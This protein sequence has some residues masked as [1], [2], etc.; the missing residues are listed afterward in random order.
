VQTPQVSN[1]M[2]RLCYPILVA[3][4]LISGALL[5]LLSAPSLVQA[6]NYQ[7]TN[8]NSSGPGS[9]RQAILDANGNAGHDTITF[10][11]GLTGTIVL[12]SALP[13]VNDHLTIAGPGASVISISGN[14]TSR[15]FE[16]AAGTAVTITNVTIRNGR[17]LEGGGIYTQGT[18]VLSDTNV[19]G[20]SAG[21]NGTGGGV[22]VLRGKVTLIGGQISGNSARLGGGIFIYEG[23]VTLSGGQI[24][25][26][27]AAN[28]G[29]LG[30][31]LESATFTQ[32]GA[33]IIAL[34]S[35][36]LGGG[37]D[38]YKGSVML[39]GGQIASNTARYRGGGVRVSAGT[40]LL[41]GG[42]IISNTADRGGGAYLALSTAI[43]TQ[44]GISSI[45]LNSANSGGGIHVDNG[46]VVISGGQIVSNTAEYY[47]GG[48]FL[49][50]GNVIM[51]GG[52]IVSN[53]AP[54]GGGVYAAG[55][56]TL[57]GASSITLN[58]ANSG[59]GIYV[60][61]G[62]VVING[63]HIASNA[64]KYQGGGVSISG[65]S[66]TLENVQFL[67]NTAGDTGGALFSGAS[68][69][70]TDSCFVGNSAIS[71]YKSGLSSLS[72]RHN[73]WGAANGPSGAGSGDGDSVS[74]NV[75]YG[76]FLTVPIL[77]CPT[78]SPDLAISKR[79]YPSSHIRDQDEV[80]YT[81]GL[82]NSGRSDAANVLL[83]DTLPGELNFARWCAK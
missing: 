7:V 49:H 56:F 38:I 43:F 44:T 10:E 51:S 29:G 24:I 66:T 64:A 36:E 65:G 22:F 53:T 71:V 8:L 46:N 83:T 31:Y 50:V 33:S 58:S 21:A 70:V 13:V 11:P 77:G 37:L 34:N 47:G 16:I 39:R 74:T 48:V 45:T 26:N 69:T 18:L 35:A 82:S 76:D 73:W 63:A 62:N 55:T 72:A 28:G 3:G 40:V 25:S 20:N 41:S 57:T 17:A 78:L 19:I 9:L 1:R 79:V 4:L 15:V 61:G 81:I 54:R 59:G 6:T 27:S 80:T 2:P 67:N 30:L 60:D 14:G 23:N 5:L 68:A 75:D 52:Q 12:A 32:T 42:Q